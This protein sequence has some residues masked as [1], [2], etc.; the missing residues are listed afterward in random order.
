MQR[1]NNEISLAELMT[2]GSSD[3]LSKF[4]A[5]LDWSDVAF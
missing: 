3:N 1:G 5:I 4:Y 2:R